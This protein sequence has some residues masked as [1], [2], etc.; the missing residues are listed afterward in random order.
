MDLLNK[1]Q[2]PRKG[3][4]IIACDSEGNV[5]YLFRC[6]CPVE[7]CTEWRCSVSGLAVLADVKFWKY[8]ESQ[9]IIR[10]L[11]S[12]GFWT[13]L[14]EKGLTTGSS[15]EGLVMLDPQ[16]ILWRAWTAI[17]FQWLRQSMSIYP[18]IHV[19]QTMEPKFCYSIHKLIGEF[20]WEDFG[21]ISDLYYDIHEAEMDCLS[22]ITD[23]LEKNKTK[24]QESL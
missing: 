17:I 1:N 11:E 15:S 16:S 6:G 14:D 20:E 13:W 18:I 22:K 19:D 3:K 10:M 23:M 8:G 7:T 21:H 9:K 24:E 12:Q 5:R 4:D 2:L